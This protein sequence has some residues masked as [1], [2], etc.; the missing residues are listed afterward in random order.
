MCIR[1][2]AIS[3]KRRSVASRYRAIHP[4]TGH[5]HVP[6]RTIRADGPLPRPALRPDRQ[7]QARAPGRVPEMPRRCLAA[8]L[9]PDQGVQHRRLCVARCVTGLSWPRTKKTDKSGSKQIASS[10]TTS[11]TSCSPRSATLAPTTTP[12]WRSWPPTPA[13]A[14]GGA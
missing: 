4:Q 13:S 6:T 12:T 5:H 10:T 8:G 11:P 2:R 3:R 14:S 9:G 7:A 1:V